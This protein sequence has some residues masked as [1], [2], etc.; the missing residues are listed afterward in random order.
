[1]ALPFP[2]NLNLKSGTTYIVNSDIEL[3]DS[4]Q[5]PDGVTLIFQGG[6]FINKTV[7][8]YLANGFPADGDNSAAL[9]MIN[10][11]RKYEIT[12]S[13]PELT[14]SNTNGQGARL[15]APLTPIF[16]QGIA[17]NGNWQI[18]FACPLWFEPTEQ[19]EGGSGTN[20]TDYADCINKAIKMKRAG[21]VYLPRGNYYVSE[22]LFLRHGITLRGDLGQLYKYNGTVIFPLGAQSQSF[23]LTKPDKTKETLHCPLFD[24]PFMIYVN[25]HP[26]TQADADAEKT[27]TDGVAVET[28]FAQS[29]LAME[30]ISL[31]CKRHTKSVPIIK[32]GALTNT[33][34]TPPIVR[35]QRCVIAYGG[36]RF[37]CIIWYD[38]IQALNYTRSYSDCKVVTNCWAARNEPYPIEWTLPITPQPSHDNLNDIQGGDYVFNMGWLGDAMLFANNHVASPVFK[39]LR[40]DH[41]GGGTICDNI[42]NG[43]VLIQNSKAVNYASNHMELGG[44][45]TIES[46]TVHL[47][48]NYIEKGPRP[49]IAIYGNKKTATTK[50]SVNEAS[51]SVVTMNNDMF[52]FYSRP[53][54]K[55]EEDKD[56]P[57]T[58][59]QKMKE[60]ISKICEYDI[61]LDD[62]S[63]VSF[64][65]VYRY[66]MVYSYDR[67][68]PFGIMLTS[69][70]G[71]ID[72]FNRYSYFYSR[73]SNYYG[74]NNILGSFR[75][76]DTATP[77]IS[78]MTVTNSVKWLGATSKYQ[79]YYEIIWDDQR[80]VKKCVNNNVEFPITLP[81]STE[82][83]TPTEQGLE[84]KLSTVSASNNFIVK[85]RRRST[86]G[87][88]N[89]LEEVNIPICGASYLF[90]N[91]ISIA[92]FKWKETI[93]SFRFNNF[94]TETYIFNNG[95]V[96]AW[97][98]QIP[99]YLHGWKTGDLLY[100]CN[101]NATTQLKVITNSDITINPLQSNKP[102]NDE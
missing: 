9:T 90:D 79:Y 67:N 61:Q 41:C 60:R 89:K 93:G 100:N 92:G 13:A 80:N 81:D 98:K 42:L 97:L 58:S 24:Y 74:K 45:L 77:A 91:G 86:S 70:D 46:S 29:W 31:Y 65:N 25:C 69:Q 21:D 94:F 63:I 18:E 73:K 37:N 57:H 96:S 71:P 54:F 2:P 55:D 33:D 5:I 72:E 47:D 6:K 64:N 38:F 50:D 17:V 12:I 43:D 68:T 99:T 76:A 40:V 95:S 66:D 32:D 14:Q 26:F 34:F 1:M 28:D 87:A 52:V 51:V 22:P 75:T 4:L 10:R 15:I 84:L 59:L 82:S 3:T 83:V 62:K 88:T 20:R 102:N 101:P 27:M 49:S 19:K 56:N 7:K 85:L 78:E 35:D 11:I 48:S 53:R 8:N 23:E 44:Q 30:N 36:A 39:L 16:G